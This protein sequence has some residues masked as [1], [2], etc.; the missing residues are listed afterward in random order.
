MRLSWPG[1]LGGLA[2]E[3]FISACAILSMNIAGGRGE[4]ATWMTLQSLCAVCG[5]GAVDC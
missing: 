2:I 5:V 3:L 4:G 1:V